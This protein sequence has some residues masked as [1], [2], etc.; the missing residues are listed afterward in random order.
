MHLF[1]TIVKDLGRFTKLNLKCSLASCDVPNDPVLFGKSHV[2]PA[3]PSVHFLKLGIPHVSY[4]LS[5]GFTHCLGQQ[6]STPYSKYL[7]FLG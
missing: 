7:L 4:I 3:F 5:C 6:Q 2:F 1:M